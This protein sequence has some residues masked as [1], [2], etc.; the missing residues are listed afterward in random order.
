M[1]NYR[2][3]SGI[4][5]NPQSIRAYNAILANMQPAQTLARAYMVITHM[6]RL[7]CQ[8]ISAPPLAQP[9]KIAG[10]F[11]NHTPPQNVI[12]NTGNPLFLYRE[13]EQSYALREISHF[14]HGFEN[15]SITAN[16]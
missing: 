12:M 6:V 11:E 4:I 5:S 15:S 3:A 10:R 13:T 9:W 8:P 16:M 2:T 7:S 14:I 1:P